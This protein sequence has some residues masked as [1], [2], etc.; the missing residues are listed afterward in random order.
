MDVIE[1]F[2]HEQ[3]IPNKRNILV[4]KWRR[5]SPRFAQGELNGRFTIFKFM[6]QNGAP[7]FRG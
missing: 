4:M 2:I 7:G 3:T 1:H 5:V 6:L